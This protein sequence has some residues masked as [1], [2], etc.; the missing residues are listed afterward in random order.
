MATSRAGSFSSREGVAVAGSF[1]YMDIGDEAMLTEDLL[2][3]TEV[4][5]LP[6]DQILL[7]GG[8]PGYV[9]SYHQHP[10][11]SCF[12][13]RQL[14]VNWGAKNGMSLRPTGLRGL[15]TRLLGRRREGFAPEIDE[16][17]RTSRAALITGGG[18]INTR[19]S[20]AASLHRMHR[21]VSYFRDCGLPIFMSGQ[22][23][24]PL[25]V[26]AAH[27]AL[28]RQIIASVDVLTVRDSQYSREY[29]GRIGAWPREF[30]ETDDDAA[31][32]PYAHEALP[33]ELRAF[34]EA[35]EAV[36][37]N[38][39]TY[40]GS[41]SAHRKFM[42][43]FCERLIVDDDKA[44]VLVSHATQ[45]WNN[46]IAI[47]RMISP[48]LQRRVC[49]PDTRLWRAG[50]LKRLISECVVA[51]GGRYHFVVFAG[52]SDTPFV[53]MCAN[54]YS[55]VKQ[56]GFARTHGLGHFVLAPEDTW[57]EPSLWQRYQE[58]K[59]LDLD[60]AKSFPRPSASMTM[61]GRWLRAID[62]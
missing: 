15:A 46:H 16:R 14:E 49:L 38:T 48:R 53:G 59:S 7:F 56:H 18:T 61:F 28:A 39:T 60:L 41:A 17:L 36:A 6:R 33:D 50:R 62:G 19:D 35:G 32:V 9:A 58:A 34:L 23:I 25:G 24:G 31:T 43:R 27:D 55:Y 8:N 26:N 40:T 21:I 2:Y 54:Q 51:V 20:R 13:S 30:L 10:P 4:I 3:I 37:V 44:V 22:T 52:T 11:S 45:D 12:P 29:L 47:L 57:R 5:G 1:G 42:A